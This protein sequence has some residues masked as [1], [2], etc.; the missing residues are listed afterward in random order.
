MTL[1]AY[2][3]Q[4]ST[5]KTMWFCSFYYQDFSGRRVK[6]KKQ[7]FSTKREADAWERD[8]LAKKN[9]SP[10]MSLSQLAENFLDD[11]RARLKPTTVQGFKDVLSARILPTF[12]TLPIDAI[13]PASV[14]QWENDMLQEGCAFGSV[15]RYKNVFSIVLNFAGRFYGLASNPVR[16]AGA[17]KATGRKQQENA[18]HVWTCE[19]F[20]RFILTGFHPEIIAV[21]SILFWTGARVGEALALTVGDIDFETSTLSITKTIEFV[22]GGFRAQSPKTPASYRRVTMPAQLSAILREWIRLTG[23]ADPSDMLF[24]LGIRGALS[25]AMHNGAS[26]AGLPFIRIHDLRHSHASMLVALGFPPIVI[27]DRLGHADI[28]TT[29][30]VYSHLYPSAGD[31]VAARLSTIGMGAK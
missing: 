16:A 12:G 24:R 21:F 18:L 25:K 19:Q 1:P 11:A 15:A 4:T 29:M 28:K 27:R 5:G 2:K 23:A 3:Y 17:L 26:A 7:G 31:N 14:R 13:T 9:G 20:A 30:N 8:F 6:K 22:R 10:S